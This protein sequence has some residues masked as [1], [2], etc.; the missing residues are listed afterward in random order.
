MTETFLATASV[1][2]PN[3]S[4]HSFEVF[5]FD[6][7]LDTDFRV[8]LIEVNTNPCLETGTTLMSKIFGQM[9]DSAFQIALDPLYRPPDLKI[10]MTT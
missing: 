3:R 9:L 5:G 6:F 7:M 4:H 8:Y 10:R 1:V 2:A